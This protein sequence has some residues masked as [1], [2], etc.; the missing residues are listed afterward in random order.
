[1]SH[2]RFQGAQDNFQEEPELSLGEE[3]ESE[4]ERD[5]PDSDDLLG[6]ESPLMLRAD[7]DLELDEDEPEFDE[8]GV[9]DPFEAPSPLR[10][11]A[12]EAKMPNSGEVAAE[13][14]NVAKRPICPISYKILKSTDDLVG[15]PYGHVFQR[16]Y[17]T[18]AVRINPVC[19]MTRLPLRTNSFFHPV[20]VKESLAYAERKR[21][22]YKKLKETVEEVTAENEELTQ[23]LDKSHK[24]I[25][26][27]VAENST[28]KQEKTELSQALEETQIELECESSTS[29]SLAEE[30]EQKII[31]NAKLTMQIKKNEA[32]INLL[33]RK[34]AAQ[35]NKNNSPRYSSLWTNRHGKRGRE[36][37]PF[38]SEHRPNKHVK[39]VYS[40]R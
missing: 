32:E 29:A 30:L 10:L 4:Q 38:D 20:A 16:E 6:D 1:M 21:S 36:E 22:E 24:K 15:T 25:K 14:P 12:G 17:I 40:Q 11:E 35:N 3:S 26:E 9:V 27:T 8:D 19:P 39:I 31:E 13:Q 7:T 33:T 37:L 23:Q 18:K 34:M 2:L 5:Y 28:L